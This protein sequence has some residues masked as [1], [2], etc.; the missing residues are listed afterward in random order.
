MMA[1]QKM[2]CHPE[3]E[4]MNRRTLHL[5]LITNLMMKARSLLMPNKRPS[6]KM[7]KKR[8][9]QANLRDQKNKSNLMNNQLNNKMMELRRLLK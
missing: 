5:E 6:K 7:P 8:S 1:N 4:D 3:L 2:E 9:H